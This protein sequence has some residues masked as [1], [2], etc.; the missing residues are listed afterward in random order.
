MALYPNSFYKNIAIDLG[1]SNT[2]IYI[3]GKGIVLREPSLIAFMKGTKKTFAVGKEASKMIGRHPSEITI[4]KPIQ[5]GVIA[6]YDAARLM[7]Q[8]FISKLHRLTYIRP[9]RAIVSVSLDV[10]E[11]E[12]KAVLEAVRQTGAKDVY[13]IEAPMACAIGANLPIEE[14]NAIMVVDIGGG[15]AE[16]SVLC[17]GGIVSKK[18]LRIGGK[19]M[20]GCIINHLNRKYNLVCGE[21]T[22]E[23]IRIKVGSAP[24]SENTDII[25]KGI[26]SVTRMPQKITVSSPE[27]K[28]II[29]TYIEAIVKIIKVT[30]ENT[31]L[32]LST[33]IMEKG[34]FISGGSSLLEGFDSFIENELSI[35]VYTNDA[36]LDNVVLGAGKL[37]SSHD[38]LHKTTVPSSAA[39]S[40]F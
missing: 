24:R 21:V 2:R 37:V 12:K 14:N 25:V 36:P 20:N 3:K 22:A 11:V 35:P 32:E 7:I 16:A 19:T 40:I 27:I 1:T 8:A 39:A 30:L 29:Q 28:H 4:V 17:L 23:E 6:N 5:N 18:T 38:L 31:P 33:E 9:L 26:H 10:T 15:T 34:I 13:L